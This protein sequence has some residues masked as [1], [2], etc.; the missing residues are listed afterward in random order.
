MVKDELVDSGRRK[1]GFFMADWTKTGVNT[2]IYPGMVLGPFAWTA[3]SAV[4]D[5]NLEPFM[6]LGPSGK[7]RIAKEKIGYIAKDESDKKFLEK[8]YDEIC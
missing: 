5:R 4:V 1:L 2:S 8:I 6:M 7:T 3:P